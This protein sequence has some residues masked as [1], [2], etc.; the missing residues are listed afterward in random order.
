MGR[1]EPFKKLNQLASS[2][3]EDSPLPSPASVRAP[4]GRIPQSGTG[5]TPPDR[6]NPSQVFHIRVCGVAFATILCIAY[7]SGAHPLVMDA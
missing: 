1:N 6:T 2:W 4:Y 3:G 7:R 5:L